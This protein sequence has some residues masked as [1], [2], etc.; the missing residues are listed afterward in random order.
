MKIKKL[1]ASFGN[2]SGSTLELSDGLNVFT[3]PNES[4]KST[5]G[6]FIV[7]MFYGVDSSERDTT[8]RLADKNRYRPWNGAP[9]AGVME[10]EVDG[11]PITIERS[12]T[13]KNIFNVFSAKNS[14]TGA[15]VPGLTGE[16]CGLQLLGMPRSVFERSAYVHQS[17]AVFDHD[18]DLERKLLS[19]VTTGEEGVSY[20]E[21]EGRLRQNLRRL[22]HNKTGELPAA[23]SALDAALSKLEKLKFYNQR[24]VEQTGRMERL[25]IDKAETEEQL[26]AISQYE[27]NET[28]RR[29]QEAES[30]Y[31][32]LKQKAAEIESS[33]DDRGLRRIPTTKEIGAMLR[34][35][36]VLSEL[37]TTVAKERGELLK[38][39][40]MPEYTGCQVL[41]GLSAEDA[42]G[43]TNADIEKGGS[44]I[45]TASLHK[46]LPI[47][48]WIIS[49]VTLGAG[50]IMTASGIG[51]I[52]FIIAGAVLAAL[53]TAYFFTLAK[54]W[55]SNVSKELEQICNTYGVTQLSEIGSIV[56]EYLVYITQVGTLTGVALANSKRAVELQADLEGKRE[57]L[58][59]LIGSVLDIVDADLAKAE[60]ERVGEIVSALEGVNAAIASAKQVSDALLPTVSGLDGGANAFTYIIDDPGHDKRALQETLRRIN[61]ELSIQSST[62]AENRGELKAIGD[63]AALAAEKQR[64]EQTIEK[65]EREY[66]AIELALSALS[67]ANEELQNRFSPAINERA[68]EIMSHLTGGRYSGMVFDRNMG[69]TAISVDDI[70]SHDTRSFSKGT[71]DQLYL[72]VRLAI[73]DLALPT[74]TP[75]P[76]IFDDAF[77]AFDDTRLKTALDWL[78]LESSWR[79]MIIFSCQDRER[80]IA[81]NR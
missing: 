59:K 36:D 43:I 58:F 64:I 19:L 8:S 16:N 79:Q 62:S 20:S 78:R 10:L 18:N 77:S 75:I 33:L 32:I 3:M 66:K 2:L 31:D 23:E 7:A 14:N 30:R 42:R 63:P 55:Q 45:K 73:C 6:A 51:G 1:T 72:A 28:R 4:G 46:N 70:V 41:D 44:L 80:Q 74:D 56:E 50:I 68:G 24:N 53:T 11:L 69:I 13:G 52:P 67:D 5:W 54:T 29:Y 76:L 22:R 57:E 39:Q 71:V 48:L 15:P 47:I 37:E 60:L 38:Q 12:S 65:R 27:D 34:G 40:A 49:A 21:A 17:G 25:N 35:L 9:A 61:K 81:D 26:R